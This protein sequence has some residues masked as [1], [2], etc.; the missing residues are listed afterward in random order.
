MNFASVARRF[1]TS[2]RREAL[3]FSHHA[4]VASLKPG[5]QTK[6]LDR[7]VERKWSVTALRKALRDKQGNTK[8]DDRDPQ[9]RAADLE[10]YLEE[11]A[12]RSR[13]VDP[14]GLS[15]WDEEPLFDYLS[16]HTI[17][18]LIENASTVAAVW[19]NIAKRLEKYL[20]QRSAQGKSFR[21]RKVETGWLRVSPNAFNEDG[22]FV[23]KLTEA[24]MAE[25]EANG[26]F[27]YVRG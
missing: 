7:A 5:D 12:Q 26:R 2:R 3:S 8:G 22:D 9:D 19:T 21:P 23:R 17:R 13:R 18:K 25:I 27:R 15:N 14:I 11:E 10:W 16:E 24:E 4:E 20:K 6:M 1:E